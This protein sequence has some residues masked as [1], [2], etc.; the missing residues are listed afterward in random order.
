MVRMRGRKYRLGERV[1]EPKR[2]FCPLFY[3]SALSISGEA[4]RHPLICPT[5]LVK[6]P[7][8]AEFESRKQARAEER[9]QEAF[10][11]EEVDVLTAGDELVCD[12]CEA[13]AEDGPYTLDEAEGLIPAH[14]NC[15]P[16]DSL[17]S[18]AGRITGAL[19]PIAPP[20]AF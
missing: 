5:G 4:D 10:G 20:R 13:I 12:E 7:A 8:E 9:L 17:V 19:K 2:S 15:L 11:E 3:V 14:V 16:G 6:F 1:L 18:P